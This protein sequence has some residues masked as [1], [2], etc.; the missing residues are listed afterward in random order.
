MRVTLSYTFQA[1]IHRLNKARAV[2]WDAV[3]NLL[4]TAADDPVHYPDILCESAAGRLVSC[5][6]ADL[7]VNG[8][9]RVHLPQAVKALHARDVMEHHNTVA[10]GESVN[11]FTDL[12][13]HA[14]CLVP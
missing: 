5:R 8:A 12:R 6:H 4:D 3:G 1:R 13:H 7:L 10:R 11:A 9:L 2:K 14:C